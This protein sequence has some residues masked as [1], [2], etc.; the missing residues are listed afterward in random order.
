MITRIMFKGTWK[1][2]GRKSQ[3]MGYLIGTQMGL[4]GKIAGHSRVT[5]A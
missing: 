2:N 4:A 5:E 1:N 3:C